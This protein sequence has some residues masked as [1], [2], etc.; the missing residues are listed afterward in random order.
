MNF[1]IKIGRIIGKSIPLRF[2]RSFILQQYYKF[3]RGRRVVRRVGGITYEL[4]LNELIDASV[5]LGIFELAVTKALARHCKAGMHVLDIGANV[6]AHA[7]P[8][9]QLVHPNGTVYAFEPTQY[10]FNKLRKNADLNPEFPIRI[11]RL[12]LSDFVAENEK[13]DFRASWLTY[14]GRQ[15]AFCHVDF[16]RLDDWADKNLHDKRISLVKIDVDGNEFQVIKGG[17]QLLIRDCPVLVMEAVSQHFIND[18]ENPF[19]WL[20]GHGWRIYS[21]DEKHR[22]SS[23][24]ELSLLLPKDDPQMTKSINV[25]LVH[26]KAFV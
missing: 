21:I 8:L 15:D 16:V 26:E 25:V 11:F 12:A 19:M 9:C 23:V 17:S 2:V 7:F 24:N 20:W 1:F 14:G 3:V 13:I 18:K 22:F 4:D 6:G 10:A 5:N